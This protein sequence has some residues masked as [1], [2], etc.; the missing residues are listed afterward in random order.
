MSAG[1]LAQPLTGY[2]M[3]Q[4]EERPK[5]PLGDTGELALVTQ[6]LMGRPQ[7]I[8]SQSCLLSVQHWRS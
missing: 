7:G 4:W 1:E 3:H 6:V 5:P 8:E 2:S